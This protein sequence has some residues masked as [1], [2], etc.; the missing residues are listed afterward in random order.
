M[1]SKERFDALLAQV[2]RAIPA[3]TRADGRVGEL[4]AAAAGLP[5][6]PPVPA[7]QIADEELPARAVV[8][9]VRKRLHVLCVHVLCVRAACL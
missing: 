2:G 4:E 6:V 3:L 8:A 7:L 9:V 5:L 1:V